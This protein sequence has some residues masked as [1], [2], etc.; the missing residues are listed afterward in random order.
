[1]LNPA[2]RV[3]VL[4]TGRA[5]GL[6]FL[7]RHP[8]R[9][10]GWDIVGVAATDPEFRERALAARERLPYLE[11]NLAL[12][13]R[14]R[15]CRRSD[16]GAR[17]AFDAETLEALETWRADLVLLVGYLHVVTAPLLD[18]FPGRMVNLHDADLAIRGPDW[19]PR[20]RGLHST[21]DAISDGASE[22]RTTAHVVTA[23]VDGGPILARSWAFPVYPLAE[24]ARRLGATDI[25]RAYAYAQRE[26]M[27][28]TAWGPLLL[29]VVRGYAARAVRVLDGRVFIGSTEGPVELPAPPAF[30]SAPRLRGVAG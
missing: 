21:R 11:R 30:G 15:G 20:Y 29:E 18:G 26:W 8:D 10:K 16:L 9:G 22:T 19:L 25:L 27:M 14:S 3:A 7:L 24:A 6:D 5:P 12:H 1:M 2:L 13:C 28:R 17:K 23:E 4:S